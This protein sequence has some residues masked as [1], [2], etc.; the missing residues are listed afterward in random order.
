MI[1]AGINSNMTFKVASHADSLTLA[2]KAD[3][4][5]LTERICDKP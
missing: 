5:F 1:W 4:M 3:H 2:I